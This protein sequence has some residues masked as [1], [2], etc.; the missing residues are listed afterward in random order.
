[1]NSRKII[2][3]FALAVAGGIWMQACKK[4]D[5]NPYPDKVKKL[6]HTWKITDITTPKAGQ[7]ETDSSILKTCMSDDLVKF[8]S[9]GFDF[10]DGAAKCDS[11]VFYYA[12]GNWAYKLVE[13][14]IQLGATTPAK[15]LS[16]KVLLLNDSIMKV[17]YTDSLNPA[18]KITKTISF[19]R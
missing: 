4:D 10:D 13:D 11:S 19:K 17:K 7:A 1:M 18:Q 9:T 2:K 3:F 14:S 8:T 5:N 15:Y 6:M 16:W 12:K